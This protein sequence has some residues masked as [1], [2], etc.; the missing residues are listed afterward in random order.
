MHAGNG[1]PTKT[2]PS[3]ATGNGDTMMLISSIL[4]SVDAVNPVIHSVR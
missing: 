4:M 1:W 3:V 2:S